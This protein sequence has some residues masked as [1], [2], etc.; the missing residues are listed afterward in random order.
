MIEEQVNNDQEITPQM[1]PADEIKT[2]VILPDIKA[3]FDTTLQKAKELS[4]KY[5]SPNAAEEPKP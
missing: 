1:L 2:P 4:E 5:S 3:V